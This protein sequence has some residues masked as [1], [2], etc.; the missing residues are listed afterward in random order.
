MARRA[1]W[2]RGTVRQVPNGTWM[3]VVDVTD[4]GGRR[5]QTRRRGFPTRYAAQVVLNQIL[6]DLEGSTYVPPSRQTLAAFLT[7]DW[8]PTIERT[9]RRSTFESYARNIRVHVAARPIGTI[10]LQ[11]VDAGHLNRLYTDLLAGTGRRPLAPRSVQYI[12]M[13]LHRA[14][15]D[16]VRWDRIMRNPTERADPPRPGR[17]PQAALMI[18]NAEQIATFLQATADDEDWIIWWLLANTGMR[19]GEALGLRWIDVDLD[20]STL[21]IRRTLVTVQAR[22][23]DDPGMAWSEPKTAKGWR[24]IALDEA[25]VTALRRHRKQQAEQRLASG[26][27]RSTDD[28]VICQPDGSPIHPKTVS[29]RFAAAI[30]RHGLPR[31]RLHDLRHSHASLALKAG[32]HPRVVQ[33]R[34]GHANVGVTL[35][36]YSHV[37]LPMQ[38]A[39]AD[40]IA[41]LIARA[42]EAD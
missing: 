37:N 6:H 26:F 14:L 22:R 2:R 7:E 1:G 34:L 21:T 29:W 40:L 9:V 17:A 35:D 36:T 12:H 28:L 27:G 4:G 8:L 5:Q 3:L 20:A 15:R 33:E 16:A 31:I 24:T 30:R 32:V 39:A 23:T 13:I 18:W 41:G 42:G 25:T 38:A 10:E 11:D 19:R